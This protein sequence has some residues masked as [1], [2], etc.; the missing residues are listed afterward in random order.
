MT[1]RG[2]RPH[3]GIES[4]A[5]LRVE[6]TLG[7]INGVRRYPKGQVFEGGVISLPSASS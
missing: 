5:E 1:E 3:T 4:V 2:H 7:D 6:G